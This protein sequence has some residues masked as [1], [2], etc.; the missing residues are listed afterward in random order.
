M[1]VTPGSRLLRGR[2]P[3]AWW[4]EHGE[5][6]DA[7]AERLAKGA[8]LLACPDAAA[9]GAWRLTGG[10]GSSVAYARAGGRVLLDWLRGPRARV[11]GQA[12]WFARPSMPGLLL[13]LPILSFLFH[14]FFLYFVFLSLLFAQQK[15]N[16][17][18]LTCLELKCMQECRC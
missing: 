8:R 17:K 9:C 12:G 18:Q 1:C 3:V 13:L 11:G 10:S 5:D 7:V 15:I 2:L 6:D 14:L 4:R 16:K